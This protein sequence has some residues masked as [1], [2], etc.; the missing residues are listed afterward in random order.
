[1]KALIIDDSL[2]TLERHKN[3]VMD[4]QLEPL[5]AE[6]GAKAL[7][8]YKEHNPEIVLCDI[9][10]PEMNGYEVFEILKEIDANVFLYFIS[11]EMTSA[12]KEKAISMKAA[13]FYQKPI[14]QKEILEIIEDYKAK[15]LV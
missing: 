4:A 14:E 1:M 8:M 10:M 5:L 9:M 6:S 7:E 15:R 2:F 11:A 12:A 3:L 13:G